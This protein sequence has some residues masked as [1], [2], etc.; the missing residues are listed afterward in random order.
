MTKNVE[1]WTYKTK[2]EIEALSDEKLCEVF[3]DLVDAII[4]F[5]QYVQPMSD[6]MFW[7]LCVIPG[8]VKKRKLTI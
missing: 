6:E 5:A 4:F 7:Q 3:K 1:N 8:E 2:A